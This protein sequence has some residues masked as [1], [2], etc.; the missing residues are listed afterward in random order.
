M[1]TY[2]Q[3]QMK[4][5][6][7]Y[8]LLFQSNAHLQSAVFSPVVDVAYFV[9]ASS[10]FANIFFANFI[11]KIKSCFKG[12][13]LYLQYLVCLLHT[14]RAGRCKLFLIK[15]YFF[16]H[17]ATA[18]DMVA[19]LPA[20]LSCHIKHQRRLVRIFYALELK[21]RNHNPYPAHQY[22]NE[23]TDCAPSTNTV[24]L[25]QLYAACAISIISFT[26]LIVPKA[27]DA[28]TIETNFVFWCD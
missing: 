8:V 20:I 12:L 22:L 9:S 3:L 24:Q 10:C 28:W 13:Q 14:C 7:F 4:Q 21:R 17:F 27:L 25:L 1:N 23:Q 11:Y 15:S 26:G 6:L 2:Q 16:Y 5:H 18:P 19:F